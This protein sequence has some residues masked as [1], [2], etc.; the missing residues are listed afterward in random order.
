MAP[1]TRTGAAHPVAMTGEMDAVMAQKV[2]N[3]A[4]AGLRSLCMKRG[5]NA[6]LAETTVRESKSY[7]EREAFDQHLIDLIEPNEQQ[8]IAALDGRTVTSERCACTWS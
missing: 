4:A 5:R 1:S 7:T 6:Q 8:L 2:E 3:D